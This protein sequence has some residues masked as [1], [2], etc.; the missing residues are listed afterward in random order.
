VLAN[1][2]S[3]RRRITYYEVSYPT[4]P[5]VQASLNK[6]VSITLIQKQ[7]SHD[8][9]ILE[10]SLPNEKAITTLKTGMPISF[11][12]TKE[13][14]TKEW[15]GYVSHLSNEHSPT[16]K[17]RMQIHCVGS[18]FPLKNRKPRVFRNKTIPQAV[19]TLVK[20]AGLKYIGDPNPQVFSQLSIAGHS[21]WEWIQEQAKKIGYA[22]L[23][24]GTNFYFK[25]IDNLISTF[26]KNA[27][28]LSYFAQDVPTDT[29]LNDRTLDYFKYLHGE[30]IE[31]T[32][33]R[34]AKT[35]SG[36]NPIT[37]GA[38]SSSK[39][40]NSVGKNLKKTA[41]D[42]FFEDQR[43]SQVAH[44]SAAAVIA[45]E[46]AA[47]SSRFTTPAK[48]KCQGNASIKPFAPV[49]I[50]GISDQV[51]GHWIA[52]NVTHILTLSGE[53]QI[54]MDV[55]T[56]G[57]GG[58]TMQATRSADGK[59]VGTIDINAALA[60][61]GTPV[62]APGHSTSSL[63]AVKKAVT[64]QGQGYNRTTTLWGAAPRRTGRAHR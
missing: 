53:Y 5:S 60:N 62:T 34:N 43:T 46:G 3:S 63:K 37:G 57:I 61:G 10:F 32:A 7:Y 2:S 30:Y 19:E 28:V 27:A 4:A 9:A 29:L 18:S 35:V 22:V 50:D 40:A 64:E 55:A 13:G 26:S 31:G 42:V 8:V 1:S 44:D 45:A 15:V 58:S 52:L 25:R 14:I 47:H 39:K 21:H 33:L 6:P 12:W 56:D 17:K 11:K 51:D 36:V 49:Y 23:V 24:E 16:P 59:L 38:V 41:S 48:V 20:E 54:E